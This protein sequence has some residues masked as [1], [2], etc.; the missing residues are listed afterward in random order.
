M[1]TSFFH[2]LRLFKKLIY[3][4]LSPILRT[5]ICLSVSVSL[6]FSFSLPFPRTCNTSTFMNSP[7]CGC[8]AV[9]RMVMARERVCQGD[10]RSCL[11]ARLSPQLSPRRHDPPA[12]PMVFRGGPRRARCL[13]SRPGVIQYNTIAWRPFLWWELVAAWLRKGRDF[14]LRIVPFCNISLLIFQLYP[15]NSRITP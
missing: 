14:L 4:Y 3:I 2:L 5:F 8:R 11:A 15:L 1:F 7:S 6:S 10:G 13:P 9:P 12:G